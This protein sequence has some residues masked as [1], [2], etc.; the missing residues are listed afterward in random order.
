MKLGVVTRELE[1]LKSERLRVQ[2]SQREPKQ[3]HQRVPKPP[4]RREAQEN[5]ACA[6]DCAPDASPGAGV[7]PAP[8]L[9]SWGSARRVS[10][11]SAAA[12]RCAEAGAALGV[13]ENPALLAMFT[14]PL[15]AAKRFC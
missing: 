13:A 7:P 4:T 3:H 5:S 6:V 9:R 14:P 2:T 11:S 12:A 10:S 8:P 15:A 1:E